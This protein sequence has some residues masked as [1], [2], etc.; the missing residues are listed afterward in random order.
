MLHENGPDDAE[1]ENMRSEGHIWYVNC[2]GEQEGGAGQEIVIVNDLQAVVGLL[3]VFVMLPQ[4]P[5]NVFPLLY[6][7]K[8]CA[9]NIFT[10]K[11]LGFLSPGQFPGRSL[12]TTLQQKEVPHENVNNVTVY[13]DF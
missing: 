10:E 11:I 6:I 1:P 5:A 2:V 8:V 12:P 13:L 9:E 7:E 3:K 4:K